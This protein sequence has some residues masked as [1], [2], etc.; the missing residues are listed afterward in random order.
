MS[1]QMLL[2]QPCQ[3]YNGF[4]VFKNAAN[5]TQYVH[6]P[7]CASS[8]G[9]DI[10]TNNWILHDMVWIGAGDAAAWNCTYTFAVH[11]LNFEAGHTPKPLGSSE[12]KGLP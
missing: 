1:S 11:L 5:T 2:N 8:C 3:V 6:T 4:S 12:G 10:C 9:A 7:P